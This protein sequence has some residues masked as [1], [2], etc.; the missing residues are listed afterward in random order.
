MNNVAA[1]VNLSSIY[2]LRAYALFFFFCNLLFAS[3]SVAN[4]LCKILINMCL[5]L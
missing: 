2:Y 4:L 3:T 5:A 1:A